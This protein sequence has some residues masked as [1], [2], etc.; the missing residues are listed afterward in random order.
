[1]RA[2]LARVSRTRKVGSK[3][4]AAIGRFW[5]NVL[6]W[7][8]GLNIKVAGGESFDDAPFIIVANHTL[9]LDTPILLVALK[10]LDFRFLAATKIFGIKILG[11]AMRL[12]GHIP[13]DREDKRAMVETY[14]SLKERCFRFGQSVAV[15]PEGTR[16]PEITEFGDSVFTRA[17]RDGVSLLPVRIWVS[18]E[19]SRVDVLIG[20]PIYTTGMRRGEGKRLTNEVRDWIKSVPRP[21]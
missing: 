16:S 8:A 4:E 15:F 17:I 12:G 10:G 5:G 9:I 21:G 18:D 1:M 20:R 14:G 19:S 6:S 13:F 3:A 11:Q 7:G 2:L